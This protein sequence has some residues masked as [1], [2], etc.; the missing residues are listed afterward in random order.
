M[1][2]PALLALLA[3]GVAAGWRRVSFTRALTLGWLLLV[4]RDPA[5]YTVELPWVVPLLLTMIIVPEGEPGRWRAHPV[6]GAASWRMPTEAR[7]GVALGTGLLGA[8]HLVGFGTTSALTAAGV[9]APLLLFLF[10]ATWIPPKRSA[11]DTTAGHE[12]LLLYDGECG[13]CNTVVLFL[14]REDAG[15]RLRFAPLQGT[16]GQAALRRAGLPTA[17]FDSLVFFPD[18]GAKTY[19]L[20]TD[21]ALR[22]GLRLGGV[23]RGLAALAV[24]IPRG[25]R[26]ALYRG[27]ARIRYRVFGTYKPAPL[28]DAT[29][30]SRFIE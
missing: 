22:V 10:P 16:V 7:W 20:R 19:F 24:I 12:P 3:C 17:D 6:P 13:L 26:D 15:A 25:W 8:L 29:W 14:I 9:V 2:I 5:R 28:P 18:R 11:H 27:V 23:W 1:I 4:V 30:A 21:G